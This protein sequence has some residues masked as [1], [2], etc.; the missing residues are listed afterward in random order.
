MDACSWRRRGSYE[1][2]Y[3]DMVTACGSQDFDI[4]KVNTHQALTN[5]ETLSGIGGEKCFALLPFAIYLLPLS[6]VLVHRGERNE[7]VSRYLDISE[8]LQ[9]AAERMDSNST[10]S[11]TSSVSSLHRYKSVILTATGQY[12]L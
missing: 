3:F 8:I 9:H 5:C 4:S 2:S 12:H 11:H 6:E 10:Y 7:E 1:K